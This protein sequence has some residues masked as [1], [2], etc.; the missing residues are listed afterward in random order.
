MFLGSASKI[1]LVF[2]MQIYVHWLVVVVHHQ[3][4]RRRLHQRQCLLQHL[5]LLHHHLYQVV[6]MT[7]QM[8][9]KMN[10]RHVKELVKLC[11]LVLV[12]H[13]G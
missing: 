7:Q 12:L 1:L 10:A 5:H 3:L 4:H 9:V 6:A 11:R 8:R 13:V 2:M